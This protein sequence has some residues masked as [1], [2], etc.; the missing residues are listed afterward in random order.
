V[1]DEAK[2]GRD[3]DSDELDAIIADYFAMLIAEQAGSSYVKSDHARTLMARI[4]RTHRSVEFKHMNISAVLGELGLP[5]IRGY[6][7]KD[8]YQKAIFPA[9]DRYLAAH[10]EIFDSILLPSFIVA[11]ADA[12]AASLDSNRSYESSGVAEPS[13]PFLSDSTLSI[14]EPP[15]LEVLNRSR[16][17][18][19]ERLVRKFDPAARDHRNRALGYAA[20]A[21]I[22]EFERHRLIAA[23][24]PDLARKVRWTSQEDGDGAGYDV[25]SYE[26]SGSDR[27]IE[28]KGT[29]GART[30]P[31]FLTR[32]E[33]EVS[34][35]RPNH[36]Q[37]YRLYDFTAAP[38]LFA[39][40]PPLENAVNFEVETWRAAFR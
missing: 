38:R 26:A 40:K 3:W 19:L 7:A 29:R 20:E 34:E 36:W 24:R 9:I 32:T 22:F 21:R 14:E 31:F 6:R 23:D 17:E 2:I 1:A 28:V 12:I 5:T 11:N 13:V 16:P 8:N 30:T 27:L 39:L 4:G 35:E 33:R 10:P 18:G 37:L 15:P 25:R